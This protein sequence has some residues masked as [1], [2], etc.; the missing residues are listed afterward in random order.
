MSTQRPTAEPKQIPVM[1]T[2]TFVHQDKVESGRLSLRHHYNDLTTKILKRKL[3]IDVDSK[4]KAK[5]ED[6]PIF[7]PA[8]SKFGQDG[9]VNK[10]REFI[11]ANVASN[12]STSISQPLSIDIRD[13]GSL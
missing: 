5:V 7:E 2:R 9:G 4:T 13:E 1:L 3:P 10:V 12:T 11:D 6:T 8:P